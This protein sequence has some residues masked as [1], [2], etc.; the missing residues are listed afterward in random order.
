MRGKTELMWWR[1]GPLG[2]LSE[3]MLR[4]IPTATP[5]LGRA[6]TE[7]DWGVEMLEAATGGWEV[8]IAAVVR[9]GG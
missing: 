8:V 1:V 5:E 4:V 3:E 9:D 6:E 2:K 7:V